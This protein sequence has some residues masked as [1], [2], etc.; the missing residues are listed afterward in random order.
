MLIQVS[1]EVFSFFAKIVND[2]HKKYLTASDGKVKFA[3]DPDFSQWKKAY[4]I[5]SENWN[6]KYYIDDEYVESLGYRFFDPDKTIIR[7]DSLEGSNEADS[8]SEDSIS[9]SVD[10]GSEK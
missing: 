8:S 7:T 5:E 4:V 9:N 3:Y 2:L 1:P 6:P 10:N